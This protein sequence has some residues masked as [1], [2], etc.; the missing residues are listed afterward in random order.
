MTLI[1]P[2]ELTSREY[3]WFCHIKW[4]WFCGD[5]IVFAVSKMIL[6]WRNCCCRDE[7]LILPC[8]NCF[9]RD[10]CGPPYRHRITKDSDND[11]FNTP[12]SSHLSFSS[13]VFYLVSNVEHTK[14]PILPAVSN[15]ISLQF[16]GKGWHIH[17]E[18]LR[19]R[20]LPCFNVGFLGV[21]AWVPILESC[22][23]WRS[24]PSQTGIIFPQSP[25]S[26]PGFHANTPHLLPL[27]VSCHAI[28][29]FLW[30]SHW[31]F[32]IHEL[33]WRKPVQLKAQLKSNYLFVLFG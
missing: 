14:P 16:S 4:K 24:K 28:F 19:F 29:L 3:K 21:V 9:Y 6:A 17:L 11:P 32:A 7:K 20:S 33:L 31:M 22:S 8:W 1:T 10:T 23:E 13:H 26:S 15:W 18:F 25:Q 27:S 12:F 2:C 30:A 5:E